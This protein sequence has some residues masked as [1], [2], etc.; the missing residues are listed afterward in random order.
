MSA[1]FITSRIPVDYVKGTYLMAGM[2]S[3]A[4]DK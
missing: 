3:V 1:I 4:I 2:I